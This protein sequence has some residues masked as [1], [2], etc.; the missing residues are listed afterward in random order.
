ML[1]L[2]ARI[3]GAEYVGAG[4]DPATMQALRVRVSGLP[5]DSF[6]VLYCG[7]CPWSRC[8]NVLPPFNELR[9]MGFTNVKVLYI[10]ENIGADWVYKGYPT[11][12]GR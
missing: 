8:P 9:S 2:Q 10:A 3:R 7:C 4:S 5:R 6:I 1:Y 11:T 12:Y